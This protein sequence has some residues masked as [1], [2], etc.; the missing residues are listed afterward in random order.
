MEQ[1][2]FKDIKGFEGKYQVSNFGNARSLD[3]KIKVKNGFRTYK[4]KPLV[5]S[6]NSNGYL[7]VSLSIKNC[8]RN[9][10]IHR[11]VAETFLPNPLNKKCVNHKDGNKQNNNIDN[12]EWNTYKENQNH[13]YDNN[14]WDLNGENCRLAKLTNKKVLQIRKLSFAGE[15]TNK[16]IAKKFNIYHSTVYKIHKRETWKHI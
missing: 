11:L 3:I 8:R 1:E 2:I 10:Y 9:A 16:E 14:L 7:G 6:T 15:L 12:L 4:G 13:A 5:L